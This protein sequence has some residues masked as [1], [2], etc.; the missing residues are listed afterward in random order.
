LSRPHS[1]IFSGESSDVSVEDPSYE[2][3]EATNFL[4]PLTKLIKNLKEDPSANQMPAQLDTISDQ[5]DISREKNEET[6]EAQWRLQ[7]AKDNL[8]RMTYSRKT[9]SQ[10]PSCNQ[11]FLSRK[12][13]QKRSHPTFSNFTPF[14]TTLLT[15]NSP[16]YPYIEMVY[17][18]NAILT[19]LPT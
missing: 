11:L 19:K 14:K 13:E 18:S 5:A 7:I 9:C 8:T 4:E 1:P 2:P 17:T 3:P 6:E 16:G 15:S 12:K 10:C